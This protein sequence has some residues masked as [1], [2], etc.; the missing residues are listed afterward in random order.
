MYA[1][2]IHTKNKIHGKRNAGT[3]S[4]LYLG[5]HLIYPLELEL[6]SLQGLGGDTV[7]WGANRG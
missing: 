2:L 3:P 4:M 7:R 6:L 5:G 1:A